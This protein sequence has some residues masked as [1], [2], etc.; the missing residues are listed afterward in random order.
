MDNVLKHYG[1]PGMKWGQRKA[2]P[3]STGGRVSGGRATLT[4]KTSK[5]TK[6]ST[7][8]KTKKQVEA[9]EAAKA[10]RKAKI[11]KGV[12]ITAGVLAAIG[13]VAVATYAAKKYGNAMS[14]SG[15]QTQKTLD[16]AHRSNIAKRGTATRSR[17]R[18][19][20]KAIASKAL[21]TIGPMR[22]SDWTSVSMSAKY[23][24]NPGVPVKIKNLSKFV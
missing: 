24:Y 13:T 2:A 17:N 18:E 23:K 3:I 15:M 6:S 12:A 16:K 4:S 9:D 5:K 20:S 21:S 19:V 7:S 22:A 11:K 8:P 1:V 10:A 14:K